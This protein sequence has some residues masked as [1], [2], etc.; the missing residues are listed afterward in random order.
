MEKPLLP[1][2][3]GQFVAERSR[4]VLI[5]DTGVQKVAEMLYNLRRSDALT[6]SGWKVANPLAPA[7]TSDQASNWVF[8][9]N[10]MNFSFWPDNEAQQCKVTYKG[11]TYTGYMTLCAAITR[12]MEEGVPITDPKYFSQMSVEELGKVLRSD[13]ETAMP[14]LQ[15]RH[16]VL[17][18]GGRVLLEHG[19]SFRSFISQAGN[20]AQKMVELIVEKIPSY[21]DEATYEGKKISFN[22]RA[23]IL[24]ADFWAV[25]ETRGE[26]YIIN[27]DCLTMF[28]DYRVPQALVY[29]GV[30]QYSD[31]LMEALKNGELLPSGDRREVEIRGCSIWSVEL[32]KERLHKMVQET[33]GNVCNINSAIID[34]YLWPFAKQH[35]KEMTH[36]PIHHTRCIYY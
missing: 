34:F 14:M 16:Q 35:H 10:T 4:D 21:R 29:L 31:A 24:V 36:I 33:D 25:M 3:S 15:E 19:G 11:T 12:A 32:I 7:S 26:G 23:Q 18:E 28:A 13:N 5:R 2:E 17:T 27:M 9:V 30:L 22:K 1:R 20:D 6:A 8:V